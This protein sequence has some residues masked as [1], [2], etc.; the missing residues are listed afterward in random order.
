M[1][2]VDMGTVLGE[3]IG[4][5][6][7]TRQGSSG[8]PAE[9]VPCTFIVKTDDETRSYVTCVGNSATLS[10]AIQGLWNLKLELGAFND[11]TR[12]ADII[13]SWIG[14]AT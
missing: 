8:R 13:R 1:Y 2:V 11:D 3:A 12:E 4:C 7:D 10:Y 9:R 6:S 14:L 5:K